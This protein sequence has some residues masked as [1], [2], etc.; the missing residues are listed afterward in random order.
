MS[1]PESIH[2][3]S[4]SG[5]W[6]SDTAPESLLNQ[7]FLYIVRNLST[8]CYLNRQ[9]NRYELHSGLTLPRE[10]CEKFFQFYF[11]N[12][13]VVDDKF[14]NIFSNPN[15]TNLKCVRLRNSKISD[16]GLEM[17]L[18]HKLIELDLEK[19]RYITDKSLSVLNQ[20]GQNLMYLTI[21]V[22]AKLLPDESVNSASDDLIC[23]P[24]LKTP[25]LKRLCIRNFMPTGIQK[26][27]M[28]FN[29][30]FQ[31][32]S[33]L[34]HLDL[35]GC[36]EIENFTFLTL[37]TNLTYLVLHN[38]A[39]VQEGL[40]S[41]LQLVHLRHLDISQSS[42]KLR[43]FR[44][45]NYTLAEIVR[46]L[47]NLVSLDISGTNLAG[48]G[49]AETKNESGMVSDIPG[50]NSRVLNPLQF[51]GLYGTQHGACRRH[52]IPAKEISGDANEKQILN[53]ATAYI[54]RSE[55]LQRVLNDL[56]HLFRYDHC[57]QISKA[58]NVVLNAM[59]RHISEKHIQISGS[60]TLFYIVKNK[61]IPPFPAK[62]KRTTI[63]TLLNGMNAHRDDDTMMRNG[64]LTLCQFKIPHD[65]LFEYERLV[66]ML[67]HI[68]SNMEQEG[69]VQ[70]IGI[71]LLN[72]LACQVD[73]YQKQLLGDLCAIEKMLK[74]I[75][76]RINR[77]VCDD[78][79]EVAWS[80]MWNVTDE[81]PINCE[82]FLDGSG[83]TLFLDCL[84][85]F[86]DKEELMRNMMGLL[87]NVAEVK[88]LRHRLMDP[89]YIEMFRKLVDSCSDGIEVSYNAAGVLSHLASDGP[90]AWRI[91]CGDRQDVLDAMVR[92]IDNWN[93]NT[94]RNINY[95]SFE[96]ILQ[97]ARVRHTPECQHWAVWALANLTRVYP[98]KYCSL[99]ETEGGIEIL[100]EV[101]G[102]DRP[103]KRIKELARQVLNHCQ[104]YKEK[105]IVEMETPQP[106]YQLD[107]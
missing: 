10:L 58:L 103:Y 99:V 48:T 53:A 59:D 39:K 12:V 104:Q 25:K 46:C 49:V 1:P 31:S 8:V 52:D 66:L 90:Q 9:T 16:E 18:K 13:G 71:Y 73:N 100:E 98:D 56:Y 40:P 69:F 37:L 74:L 61:D 19:C 84:K 28:Y 43:T 50:L 76:D 86:P 83:M 26:D 67:L 29:V 79:L 5:T 81:T 55:V 68:V 27:P 54:D 93:L 42:D 80:T 105:G 92:A 45:E 82:R 6:D 96:P 97:L 78:V 87:G 4:S 75:A 60:A 38:V 17:L 94:E 101:V 63:T 85:L 34:T 36:I 35:S 57:A 102:D 88:Y 47:P 72:S 23:G 20:Y 77:R 14:V 107:G 30:S 62:I 89:K 41:I 21:G 15:A 51:L 32:L 64:C 24:I 95:R 22:G 70:R 65:V 11:Q 2:E 91:E 3:Y 44:N 33:S 106:S 7:C